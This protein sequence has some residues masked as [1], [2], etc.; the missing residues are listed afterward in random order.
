MSY[1]RGSLVVS[2][3]P[4]SIGNQYD[5][6]AS[7]PS[8]RYHRRKL[9]ASSNEE[10]VEEWSGTWHLVHLSSGLL[11]TPLCLQW[12]LVTLGDSIVFTVGY[13]GDGWLASIWRSGG[14]VRLFLAGSWRCA[15]SACKSLC[16]SPR[17]SVDF[18]TG[19]SIVVV[20]WLFPSMPN[21]FQWWIHG[22]LVVS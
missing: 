5:S 18:S 8:S 1:P 2:D 22:L 3:P 6:M 19:N 21:D 7:P 14:V 10:L 13:R 20:S 16:L 11:M 9:F 12:P 17:E 15:Q 4:M